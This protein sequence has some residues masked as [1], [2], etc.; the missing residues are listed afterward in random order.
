MVLHCPRWK[1][2]GGH[3]MLFGSP[4]GNPRLRPPSG[5]AVPSSLGSKPLGGH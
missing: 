1:P 5:Q 2:L 4:P 3:Q